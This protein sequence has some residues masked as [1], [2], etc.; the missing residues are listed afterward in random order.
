MCGPI[1]LA[2][3]PGRAASGRRPWLPVALYHFS[4]IIGYVAFGALFGGLGASFHAL[5]RLHVRTALPYVLA[6]VLLGSAF[7]VFKRIPAPGF[8]QRLLQRAWASTAGAAGWLRAA[9]I[10]GTTALLPC[11]MLYANVPVAAASGSA[12]VGG[13]LLAAFA[14]GSAPSLLLVQLQSDWLL[15]KLGPRRLALAQKL[16]AVVAA[17][18]LIARAISAGPEARSCCH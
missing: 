11:G 16:L 5:S 14:L 6:A 1:S 15:R 12:L 9:A 10:G 13:G 3:A 8:L 18:A 2:A 4:R 17:A 7:R